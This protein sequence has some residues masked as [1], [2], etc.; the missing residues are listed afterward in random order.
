MKRISLLFVLALITGVLGYQFYQTESASHASSTAHRQLIAEA[1][2]FLQERACS[3]SDQQVQ[4]KLSLTPQPVPLMKPVQATLQLSGLSSVEAI[5][6]KIEGLNMY[7]GFQTVQLVKQTAT[8]WQ[9]SFSLPVCSE[10]EMH[11]QV[12]ASVDSAPQAY[13]ARFKLVTQR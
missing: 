4:L 2:C 13:Q 1:N 8:D 6:L 5:E 9:G 12:T 3:A 10:S 7:M 11:W